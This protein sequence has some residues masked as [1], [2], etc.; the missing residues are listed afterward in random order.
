MYI[1]KASVG[2]HRIVLF[3]VNLFNIDYNN[4]YSIMEEV[5]FWN[6]FIFVYQG[7]T[8]L[9]IKQSL[10]NLPSFVQM[11]FSPLMCEGIGLSDGETM[12]HLWSYLRH[13]GRMTKEM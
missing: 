2:R 11:A 8:P 1:T 12:E 5:M 13:F 7:F 9:V 4:D 3:Y 10:S 6:E